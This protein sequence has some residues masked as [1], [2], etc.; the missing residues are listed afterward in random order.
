MKKHKAAPGADYN[1][2]VLRPLATYVGEKLGT[3]VLE[4]V[5][6]AGGLTPELLD[7]RSYWVTAR[8]FE[9]ILLNARRRMQD[10]A[11]FKRACVHKLAE[12]YGPMRFVLRAFSPA[13]VF[14]RSIET[15]HLVSTVGQHEVIESSQ[16]RMAARWRASPAPHRLVCLCK[17]AQTAALPT[18]WGLPPA[19]LIETHCLAKGDEYCHYEGTWFSPVP[20]RYALFG[21]LAGIAAAYL[22][23]QWAAI[24][25]AE[26]VLLPPLAAVLV[27]I[28]FLYRTVATNRA[29]ELS[30]VSALES[31]VAE[32]S[33]ARTELLRLSE[34]QRDWVRFLEEER[35]ARLSAIRD[36][37]AHFRDI[38]SS[39]TAVLRGVSHDLRNPLQVIEAS[40]N[41][42]RERFRPEDRDSVG[43]VDD[44]V[45][46]AQQMGRLLADLNRTM[47]PS[48]T[49]TIRPPE[50]LVVSELTERVRR[51][52]F[53]LVHGKD[54]RVS[55]FHTR[56]APVSIQ[57]DPVIFDR[58]LDNLLTNA[59]KYTNRG[60]ILVEFDGSPGFLVAKVSDTGRGIAHEDLERSFTAGGSRE[61]RRASNSL[62]VGLSVVVQLLAEIG[63]RLEVMSKPDVGTTFWLH[64]PVQYAPSA[65]DSCAPSNVVS[66]RRPG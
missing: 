27:H 40:I 3:R 21:F 66:I 50:K 32:E 13:A 59:V 60:S 65:E 7:G 39:R 20:Y 6:A 5:C 61:D 14:R 57:L 26:L 23:E 42:L 12:A 17:Q 49:T 22:A 62:G 16:N 37:T 38:E 43:A 34:T 56:E 55:A 51:R 19:H 46:A 4:E 28:V 53:A 35:A 24:P 58:L 11:E 44:I 18:L 31:V 2:K 54:I 45:W 64:L 33:A 8:A 30:I 41:F 47:A 9:S 63:G 10:D 36:V 1:V 25:L 29:V 48:S 15:Y 52:L